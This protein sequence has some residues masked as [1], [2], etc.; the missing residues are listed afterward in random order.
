MKKEGINNQNLKATRLY[1]SE[2][3]KILGGVAGGLGEYFGIDPTLIRIM[4]VLITIFGGVGVLLYI[5]L[6]VIVP[7]ESDLNDGE[8]KDHIKS[9]VKEIESRAE[10][11]AAEISNRKPD[12]SDNRN[13]WGLIIILVGSVFLL[14]NFKIFDFISFSKLWPVL[15]IAL[16]MVI[17]MR[18]K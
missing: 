11:F 12:G 14:E 9:N 10:K 8:L 17:L 4:F 2:K 16:G 1:R 18:R 3:Y 6:W 15:L 7:S 13:L 5:V